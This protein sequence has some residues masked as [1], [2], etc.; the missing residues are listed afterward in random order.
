MRGRGDKSVLRNVGRYN[1][2]LRGDKS[3]GACQQAK[4][5]GGKGF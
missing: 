2:W 1:I 3:S 5:F 4:A